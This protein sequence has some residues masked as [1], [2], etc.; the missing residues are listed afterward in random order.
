MV[1]MQTANAVVMVY[2]ALSEENK[3]KF[4]KFEFPVMVGVTWKILEKAGV[5]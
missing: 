5:D 4:I 1:D 2:D 3:Q